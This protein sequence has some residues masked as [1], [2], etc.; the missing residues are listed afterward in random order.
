[1][2]LPLPRIQSHPKCSAKEHTS[3]H[4]G[5]EKFLDEF[6]TNVLQEWPSFHEVLEEKVKLVESNLL[7]STKSSRLGYAIGFSQNMEFTVRLT[8]DAMLEGNRGVSSGAR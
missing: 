2:E 1:M 4:L 6:E 3:T 7:E 8:L 5:P